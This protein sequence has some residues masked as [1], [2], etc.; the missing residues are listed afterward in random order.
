MGQRRSGIVDRLVLAHHAAQFLGQRARTRLQSRIRQHF[1][2]LDGP[3][4]RRRQ[5]RD[6][7]Q[8]RVQGFHGTLTPPPAALAYPWLWTSPAAARRRAT[9][10]RTATGRRRK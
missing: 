6:Q 9:A 3:Q 10:D 1:V 5:Q 4:P 8:E 7:Q 2:R